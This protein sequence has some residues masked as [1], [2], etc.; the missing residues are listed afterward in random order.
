MDTCSMGCSCTAELKEIINSS[1]AYRH[2]N[3]ATYNSRDVQNSKQ[4]DLQ[5]TIVIVIVLRTHNAIVNNH[6][7]IIQ[8]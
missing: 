8:L 4:D 1:K 3:Y 5:I 6:S 2:L 7:L